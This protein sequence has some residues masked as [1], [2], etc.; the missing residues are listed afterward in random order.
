M[1]TLIYPHLNE[2]TDAVETFDLEDCEDILNLTR[3]L[4]DGRHPSVLTTVDERRRPQARWMA[5]VSFDEFPCIYCLTA[6]KSR[7]LDQ[8]A[9][10]PY[11]NW[12]FSNADLTLVLNLSGQA[13]AVQEVAVTKHIWKAIED[14]SHAYFLNNFTERPGVMAIRTTVD[15]IECS[16]PHAN[17]HW[18]LPLG[19]LKPQL[20]KT[21]RT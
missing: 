10:N 2:E 16:I 11:V 6:P 9:R 7:K 13:E 3:Q 4:I 15:R 5:T 17:L 8:L 21:E 19:T 14:K 20:V 18:E 12:M 1:K